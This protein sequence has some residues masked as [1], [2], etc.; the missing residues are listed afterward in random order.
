[1]AKVTKADLL[2]EIEEL[3]KRLTE[4]HEVN[5][6]LV[7][8]K[9]AMVDKADEGFENSSTYRQMTKEIDMLKL[10]LKTT[11][12]IKESYKN[13]CSEKDRVMEEVLKENEE[14]KI[15]NSRLNGEL[16]RQICDKSDL[17]KEIDS[18][19]K[20]I[21]LDNAFYKDNDTMKKK[22]DETLIL[23]AQ[24][25]SKILTLERELEEYRL[26]VKR[27]EEELENNNSVHKIKNER[28]AGRKE[29][30]TDKQKEEI[31]DYRSQGKSI[32]EI[33]EIY[34]CSTGLIH[35]LI[36]EKSNS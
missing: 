25:T 13:R 22:L 36:N 11:D 3:N 34:K 1:M 2:K 35:K 18:L 23:S 19:N 4:S 29:R 32:R 33:A 21:E 10:H 28:G 16:G 24:K 8:E 31:K 20:K 30:F 26:I 6:R 5:M 14:L 9:A 27:L 17:R 7:N 12:G 15:E